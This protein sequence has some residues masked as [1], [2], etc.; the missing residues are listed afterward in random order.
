MEQVRDGLRMINVRMVCEVDHL[1]V[2]FLK[3]IHTCIFPGPASR[4]TIF[5]NQDTWVRK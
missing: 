1:E 4:I 3:T 2:D 5:Q